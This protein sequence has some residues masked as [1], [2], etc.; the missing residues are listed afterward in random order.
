MSNAVI[1][2]VHQLVASRRLLD[3]PFYRAWSMG[4]LTREDLQRYAV[5]YYRWVLAFPTWLS[6]AHSNSPDLETRQV[7]L[8]N[9]I[10]EERGGDHHPEL[11]LRFCD[12]LGLDRRD[13]LAAEPSAATADAIGG[14]TR[15]CRD[16]DPV[17]AV[18]ALYAYESQ[19]PEVMRTKRDG[20][21]SR[22]GVTSGHDYFVVHERADVEHSDAERRLVEAGAAGREEAI[23]VAVRTMLDATYRIL[24]GVTPARVAV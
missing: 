17:A 6:A 16:L 3:H 5:Q 19:Q 20:L 4:S 13:V 11:W 9:L 7:L 23:E 22:Y 10:D 12:A 24:D 15:L 14:V 8:E 18:A 1:D 21:Q 2:R